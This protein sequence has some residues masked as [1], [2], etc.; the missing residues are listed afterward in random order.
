MVDAAF[1]LSF[2][3]YVLTYTINTAFIESYIA[4]TLSVFSGDFVAGIGSTSKG[5]HAIEYLL[6]GN[7]SS[8]SLL[9]ETH[10]LNYLNALSEDL[11][12]E[13]NYFKTLWEIESPT[14]R[15]NTE[16]GVSGSINTSVNAMISITEEMLYYKLG[17]VDEFTTTDLPAYRSEKSKSILL[18]NL[19][20][21]KFLFQGDTLDGFAKGIDDYADFLD[22][23]YD[24]NLLS[25][26]I[27]NQIETIELGIAALN[28]GLETSL[29]NEQE[30]REQLYDDIHQL[31][32]LIK[33]E[34][35]SVLTITV[36]ISDN[37]GD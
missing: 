27:K 3:S 32:I 11:I 29:I 34:L 30:R 25:T 5:L 10:R 37:D 21:L 15:A 36:T 28:G 16:T 35:A 23:Q 9:L 33:I 12:T 18:G 31:L 1:L 2:P 13:A 14:Y 19:V 17:S 4:A 22:A 26:E 20:S 24:G 7:L 6:Y 8:D